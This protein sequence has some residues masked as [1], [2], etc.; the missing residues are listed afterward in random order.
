[1]SGLRHLSR[2]ASRILQHAKVAS[3]A[4]RAALG[5]PSSVVDIMPAAS[6]ILSRRFSVSS[7]RGVSS[8]NSSL[9]SALARATPPTNYGLRIV[10]ERTAFVIERFGKYVKTLTPGLHLLIPFVDR[11]AYVHS[12]KEMAI[13]IPHQSAITRDNVSIAIDGIL[14]VRVVDPKKASYGV[15]NPLFAMTQL[16][17]TTMRSDIGKISLDK[18]FEE[19]DTL[20]R[21]IVEAIREATAEW[22]IECL[23]YEIRDISPP[24]GVRAAMELQA[25]AER[26]KRAQILESEG[27]RQS[28]INVEEGNKAGIILASEAARQDSIN[29]AVG[30]AEAI[31]RRAEATAK[32][33]GQ[34]SAAIQADGGGSAA[35]MRIA[36]QYLTA[37]GNIAKTGNTMLL[38]AAGNDPASMVAQ[39]MSIYST[40]RQ[41]TAFG[42][43]GGGSGGDDS[44]STQPQHQT[45]RQQID[46]VA[47]AKESSARP[48][49]RSGLSS[50]SGSGST[51]SKE[52][53]VASA[54]RAPAVPDAFSPVFSLQ[55]RTQRQ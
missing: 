27:A 40:V 38:P 41:G 28:K 18:T 3:L 19:R 6:L 29:R 31:F 2:G 4:Q 11:I 52:L 9:D 12:L 46:A 5:Q 43:S 54:P 51:G 39:A 21:N 48:A 15:E 55:K 49:I 22:G 36:E 23:R 10:P 53:H 47:A 35:S 32:G 37:F 17:Q 16:A 24:A 30:E 1:M 45:A 14:Y 8:H 34:L 7:P 42:P 13:P 25:E 33:L 26:R 44:G 20:N 50:G